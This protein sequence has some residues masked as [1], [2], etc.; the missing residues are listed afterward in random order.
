VTAPSPDRTNAD[1][2]VQRQNRWDKSSSPD[3]AHRDN[4]RDG[5]FGGRNSEPSQF[6]DR[7]RSREREVSQARSYQRDRSH[8]RRSGSRDRPQV[9][10]TDDRSK[11][12]RSTRDQSVSKEPRKFLPAEEYRRFQESLHSAHESVVKQFFPS[13]SS[14]KR[15]YTAQD[16]APDDNDESTVSEPEYRAL[17]AAALGDNFDDRDDGQHD[18]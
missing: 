14:S 16:P 8:S 18:K 2:R 10:F 13:G 1:R 11:S 9:S 7:S 15:A 3:L 12:P 4:R 6:R 17:V 5:G